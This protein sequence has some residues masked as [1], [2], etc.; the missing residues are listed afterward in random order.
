MDS[1]EKFYEV[2]KQVELI[3]DSFPI[4][5]L[6]ISNHHLFKGLYNTLLIS[7]LEVEKIVQHY[8][9]NTRFNLELNLLPNEMKKI[10]RMASDFPCMVQIVYTYKRGIYVDI[11]KQP[12]IKAETPYYLAKAK[13]LFFPDWMVMQENFGVSKDELL[14]KWFKLFTK[15]IT[16]KLNN[17]IENELREIEKEFTIRIEN[18]YKK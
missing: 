17:E 9:M 2:C 10:I 1:E 6:H 15:V 12:K 18:I 8:L 4:L 16:Q 11:G 5:R 3:N 13:D 14:E 7:D